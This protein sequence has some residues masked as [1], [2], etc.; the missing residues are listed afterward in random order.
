MSNWQI[1]VDF[2]GT[3]AID[4]TTDLILERFGRPGWQAIE[5]RWQAGEIG[6][7]ECMAR[8]VALI[9]ASDTE[10]DAYVAGLPIDPHFSR[11]AEMCEQ[12]ALPLTVLSDGLDRVVR[13]ALRRNGLG[14]LKVVTNQ[15]I[16]LG[17]RRWSIA[18][19]A[20]APG[21]RSAS[22]TCKCAA[23]A[24]NAE[25]MSLL[26]GDG[27]SDQC[28][29]QDVDFVFAKKSLL[30]FCQAQAIP[31]QDFETFAD[32]AFLLHALVGGVPARAMIE[33]REAAHA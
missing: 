8:Q 33:S 1:L 18:F 20:A 2:D 29:A 11:F 32:V 12:L 25:P 7:R 27:R 6:S 28:A 3:V 4:D 17:A 15:L 5:A 10:L 23:A 9:D 31:H 19:P 24:V 14:H 26:I 30:A 22:G 13:A 16:Y 21:C